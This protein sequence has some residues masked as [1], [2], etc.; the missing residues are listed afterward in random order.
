MLNSLPVAR[1]NPSGRLLV[2][3]LLVAV[4]GAQSALSSNVEA[5]QLKSETVMKKESGSPVNFAQIAGTS[6]NLSAQAESGKV[7]IKHLPGITSINL[8]SNCPAHWNVTS[9]VIRQVATSGTQKGVSLRADGMG[10]QVTVGGRIYQLPRGEDGAI[11]NLKV[12]NG[13][14]LINGK[15]LEPLPGSDKP[16]DCTG[17]EMLT[18]E[19]PD[20]FAGDLTLSLNGTA[21]VELDRW[22]KGNLQVNLNGTSVF[23][24]G[25]LEQLDKAVIDVQGT[26]LAKVSELNTKVLVANITGS[27]S[28]NIDKGRA[29]M[30]NATISG[31][32]MMVLK[33]SYPNLKKSVNGPGMIQ[34]LE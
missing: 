32:G 26:G 7:V 10:A 6:Q 20:S 13:V 3:A 11:R 1:R 17:P 16:G 21:Q 14:V 4:C 27:G 22:K 18:V 15:K 33:G 29:Q 25:L 2:W 24:S 19:V 28:L 12:E 30:S 9:G 34:V 8:K 31:A 23:Q 5:P